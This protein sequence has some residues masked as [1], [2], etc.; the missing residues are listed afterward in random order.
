MLCI[1]G[2]HT[3]VYI[4]YK[5]LKEHQNK[6]VKKEYFLYTIKNEQKL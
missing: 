3:G 4:L 5:T 2:V 6:K 1:S